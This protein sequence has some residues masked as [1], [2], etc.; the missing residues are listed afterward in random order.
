MKQAHFISNLV[1]A[2]LLVCF[3][4]CILALWL[5]PRPSAQL[6]WAQEYVPH[7]SNIKGEVDAAAFLSLGPDYEI[8]ATTNG[9]AVFKHPQAAFRALKTDYAAGIALIR[10]EHRLWP[11][12]N[13]TF[14]AYS[15]YGWQVAGGDDAARRQAAF[16]SE[17]LDIYKNSFAGH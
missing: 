13:A 6:A 3:A 17:F 2:G 4:G 8:G 16:V 14:E 1:S 15:A 5:L 12:S 7:T 10:K 9:V 11:L